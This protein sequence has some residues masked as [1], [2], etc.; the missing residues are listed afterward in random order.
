MTDPN[1]FL[2]QP[3]QD[4]SPSMDSSVSDPNPFMDQTPQDVITARSN[5][6]PTNPNTG[7]A[8][9]HGWCQ[10]FVE[11]VTRSPQKF[12]SASDAW[13]NYAQNGQAKSGLDGVKPGDPIYFQDP[14]NP[15]GHTGIYTGN[16]KFISAT[17]NGVM[18]Q[19]LSKWQSE[20][21]QQILGF[22]PEGR[23]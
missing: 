10:A 14:S 21:G 20:T 3:T 17:D 2:D 6:L 22:I 13:N 7:N 18:E 12:S 8:D 15:A 4:A 1:P 23:N 16:G 9:Y 19:P 11:Q 5:N